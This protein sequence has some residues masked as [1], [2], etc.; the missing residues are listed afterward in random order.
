MDGRDIC[1]IE[2]LYLNQSAHIKIDGEQ[3]NHV[4]IC[5]RVRQ[6]Y[7]LSPLLFNLYSEIIFQEALENI[8]KGIRVD[9]TWIN[10]LMAKVA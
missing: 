10:P 9:A 1:C 8:E 4:E 6:G 2:N 5:G 7:V 3:C